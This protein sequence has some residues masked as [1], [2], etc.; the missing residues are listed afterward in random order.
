MADIRAISS[1]SDFSLSATWFGNVVPGPGDVAFTNGN[2]VLISDART[3]QALSNLAGTGIVAG[4]GFVFLDG[5]NLTATNANGLL[6]GS[7]LITTNLS[8]GQSARLSAST[9]TSATVG[10]AGTLIAHGTSGT[11]NLNG[12]YLGVNQGSATIDNASTGTLNIT[13]SVTAV[14]GSGGSVAPG[15]RLSGSGTINHTGNVF[16][17]SNSVAVGAV[18]TSV[19][20]TYNLTGNYT[21]GSNGAGIENSSTGF[22]NAIGVG[23]SGTGAPAIGRGGVGQNTRISGPLELGSSGNINPKQCQRYTWATTLIPTYE[24]AVRSDS[25]TRRDLYSADNIPT[26]NWPVA[27]NVV[28]PTVYGP[29]NELT[30][31]HISPSPSSVAQGVPVGNTVGT[32][33]LTGANVLSALGMV[34]GNMDTKFSQIP[35]Q[36]WSNSTRTLTSGGGGGGSS[37]TATEIAAEVWSTATRT[38][39][40][41]FPSIPTAADIA[42]A[43]WN[44][45]TRTITTTIPSAI[46]I[47]VAVWGAVT[48]T[49]TS[50]SAPTATDVATAVWANTART[51]TGG[52]VNTILDKVGYSLTSSE[53]LAIATAVEQSIL[54]END[55][56][57]ILNAIV[58]AIG[59][60]NIDQ[61]TLIAAIR[62]DLE[63][64]G[65]MLAGRSTLTA[66]G[67]RAELSTELARLDVAVSSRLA[68]TGTLSTVTTLTNAPNV[69]SAA[70]IASQV[71]TELTTELSRLDVATS[72]RLASASY[73]AAPT[74]AAIR[75]ELSVELARLD[76][77]VSSRL[78]PSGTLARVTLTD[79]TT[80]L[81]SQPS[82]P[83]TSEIASAV[84]S[85]P[86]RT[87]T[88]GSVDK[89]GYSLT[90]AERQAIATA[91]E[92]SILNESDGQAILNAI[93]GAIGNSSVDQVA[94]VAAIRADMERAGGMLSGRSTLTAAQ[95]WAHT[96]RTITGGT[97]DNAS[98]TTIAAGEVAAAIRTELN[99]E[100]ERLRNCSTMDTTAAALANALK[101]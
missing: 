86:S 43:V 82:F 29:N 77:P 16:G 39:T 11:F 6:Y 4:G 64:N 61:V 93:V 95:V 21:G 70:T 81:T 66:G 65:G 31:T 10:G 69:P 8:V 34:T 1:N 101:Q 36:V 41:A 51:I 20:G 12:T 32:A 76:T 2:T 53:R 96:S 89:T 7:S 98:Q 91:V 23:R 97:I 55:G 30:G 13:G 48:R 58:G 25:S 27:N 44:A 26:G 52:T 5:G 73:S 59:N 28:S 14:G 37:P 90:S 79:T 88:G 100:L 63:R 80:T 19:S 54:N 35:A 42:T 62:A 45:A 38:L 67:V 68:P 49:L 78:A 50:S 18:N 17:S 15:V 72:T 56:Q 40:T 24:Q 46:D 99:P 85:T 47:A 3:V 75:T 84:W 83:A 9:T 87:V 22:F 60:T 71:R 74:T 92:Q 94:L 57:A 33:I